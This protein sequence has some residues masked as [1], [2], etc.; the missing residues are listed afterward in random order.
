MFAL[1][2]SSPE[3]TALQ[4]EL[5]GFLRKRVA[6]EA[7]ELA[8]ETWKRTLAA[9]P[10]CDDA[11][12]LRA[13][14]FTVARRV[15]V[16]RH[17]RVARRVPLTLLGETEAPTPDLLTPAAPDQHLLATQTAAVIQRELAA[18][19]PET[20]QV[21]RWR[22]HTD[23]SFRDIAER[24]G[25]PLNTA[26]GRHHRAVKRIRAALDSAGLGGTP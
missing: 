10:D 9:A 12:Q 20:A 25:V 4:A 1:V 18:M 26:L 13:Y 17:R 21:F 6:A 7:D 24:Q 15:L 3:L 11:G 2:Q 16:D 14:L 19:A 22:V 8:Q 23:L 5:L